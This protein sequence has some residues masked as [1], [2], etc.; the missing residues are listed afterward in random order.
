MAAITD[1]VVVNFA[2]ELR[3]FANAYVSL[4]EKA[5]KINNLYNGGAMQSKLTGT[6][7]A[8]TIGDSQ[9]TKAQFVNVVTRVQEVA[10]ALA[11]GN[12]SK[13]HSLLVFIEASSAPATAP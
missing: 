1:Q 12:I 8:D 3:G 7:N 5:I 2:T 6:Q 10:A 11:N 9:A 4:A 13:L